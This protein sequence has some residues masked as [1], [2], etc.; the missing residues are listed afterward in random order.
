[1]F[2]RHSTGGRGHRARAFAAGHPSVDRV[3]NATLGI[4]TKLDM[5]MSAADKPRTP[6]GASN[7]TGLAHRTAMPRTGLSPCSVAG[8]NA[9]CLRSRRWPRKQH[10]LMAGSANDTFRALA[11]REP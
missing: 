7:R 6:D 10:A 11:H 4:D 9:K 3:T 2:R 8:D 1:V 5:V